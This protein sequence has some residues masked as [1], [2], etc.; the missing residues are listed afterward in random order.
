MTIFDRLERRRAWT[1]DERM[2]LDQVRRLCAE[3]IAPRAAAY[4]R[5]GEFPWDNIHAINA[6]GLNAL[7]LPEE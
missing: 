4:D 7:F 1:E 6:L 5:S 2:V 3:Q